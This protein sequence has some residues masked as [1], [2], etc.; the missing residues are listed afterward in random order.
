MMIFHLL[1]LTVPNKMALM[2][3]IIHAHAHQPK[4]HP[5]KKYIKGDRGMSCIKNSS[6]SSTPANNADIGI[7][8][9]AH[10]HQPNIRP[11]PT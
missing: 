3:I 8:T 10:A 9:H 4:N 5:N 6:T 2:G 1:Q 7:I 11:R